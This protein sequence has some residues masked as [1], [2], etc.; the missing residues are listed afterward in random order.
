MEPTQD[1]DIIPFESENVERH[2]T[3]P[4]IDKLTLELFMNKKKYKK[5]VEQTDPKKYSE[6]QAYNAD[7]QKYR[8]TI[9]NM[10]DDLLENP[11]MQITREISELFESYTR[12]IIHY[13][14]NKE[15]EK[16]GDYEHPFVNRR[17]DDDLMFGE[18]DEPSQTMNSFWSNEQVVKTQSK[19]SKKDISRFGTFFPTPK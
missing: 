18:L 8:A 7:I 14:K 19:F 1:K 4:E 10:T 15:L 2:I 3:N 5:Y 9:L 6:I 16:I 12:S 11:D 17:E 13:L